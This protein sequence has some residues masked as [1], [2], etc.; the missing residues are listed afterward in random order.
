MPLTSPVFSADRSS[1][2]R[3]VDLLWTNGNGLW[4]PKASLAQS[5]LLSKP[6]PDY[7]F[8][9]SRLETPL[10]CSNETR[11]REGLSR[12]MP[13]RTTFCVYKRQTE[14]GSVKMLLLAT[15]GRSNTLTLPDS[16]LSEKSQWLLFSLFI[17]KLC[18]WGSSFHHQIYV[19]QGNPD[20]GLD[21]SPLPRIIRK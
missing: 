15:S 17:F 6:M 8:S 12:R 3:S 1:V 13:L 18:F 5:Q 7:Q 10:P 11:G 14:Q 2:S 19:K 20:S 9:K 21:L 4:S 16:E